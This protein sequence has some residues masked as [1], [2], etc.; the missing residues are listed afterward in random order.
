MFFI[1][2]NSLIANI[3][4]TVKITLRLEAISFQSGSLFLLG[5]FERGFTVL[6]SV[7]LYLFYPPEEAYIK[8]EWIINFILLAIDAFYVTF[9][10]LQVSMSYST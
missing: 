8:Q 1:D 9:C 4:I 2:C 3:E 10:S 7:K 6:I 5:S